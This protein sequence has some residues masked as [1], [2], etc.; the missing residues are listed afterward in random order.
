[1]PSMFAGGDE[2]GCGGDFSEQFVP[3][4]VDEGAADFEERCPHHGLIID[5]G[6]VA[7]GLPKRF[8]CDGCLRDWVLRLL[9]RRNVLRQ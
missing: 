1:M 2:E 8:G 5:P 9:E 3:S 6:A 7:D 4:L